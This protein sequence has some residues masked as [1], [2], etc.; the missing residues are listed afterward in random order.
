MEKNS[1]NGEK[2]KY[3]I[4]AF[5]L[6]FLVVTIS[7]VS[8]Y[9]LICLKYGQSL[10]SEEIKRYTCWHDYCINICTTDNLYPTNP[11]FCKG[12]GGCDFLAGA[13]LD[14]EPP[15]ITVNNPE[16]G[17]YYNSRG[18]LLDVDS[19]EPF[20]LFYLDNLNSRAKWKGLAS[21]IGSYKRKLS[22]KEG[23][24][25]ITVM[26]RDRNGNSM[27]VMR[28]F[29]VDSKKP[30]IKKVEPTKGFS[31]GEFYVE[32]LEANPRKLEIKYGNSDVGYRNQIVDLNSCEIL[33]GKS[34]NLGCE[35]SVD[36]GNY[37][38]QS[39]EYWFELTDVAN[40]FVRSKSYWISVDITDPILNNPGSF[41]NYNEGGRYTYFSL[42]ITE[43]NFDKVIYIDH[44]DRR[45][46]WKT[47]CTR[48]KNDLC[49]KRLTLS[50][51]FHSID[52]QII[53][54][55]GNS[56]GVNKEFEVSY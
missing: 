5:A 17:K 21:N 31:N 38:M 37:N 54:K 23:L 35:V 43:P 46:V 20:S 10:P 26:G 22:F 15:N 16:E 14:A 7:G 13:S 42:D 55:A 27:E 44:S 28:H 45:P 6:I 52:V 50:R 32:I 24:N 34:D 4:L 12:M 18:I 53:D 47:L 8:A 48:L 40:N 29:Y 25:N 3:L 2:R 39:L 56:I 19:N 51:G 36:V 49:E 30:R 41:L 33:R 11:G 1:N 9:K